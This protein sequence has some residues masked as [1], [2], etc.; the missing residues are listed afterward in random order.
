MAGDGGRWLAPRMPADVTGVAVSCSIL[1]M[2][3]IVLCATT[4]IWKGR[5]HALS[6]WRERDRYLEDALHRLV[7]DHL[8]MEGSDAC[9]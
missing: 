7:R 8:Y 4:Y 6:R 3:C 2:P 1:K 5:M 9:T